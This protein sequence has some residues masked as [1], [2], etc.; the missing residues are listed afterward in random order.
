MNINGLTPNSGSSEK[1]RSSDN[2]AK[3]SSERLSSGTDKSSSA[4][5]VEL[6]PEAKVLK[7]LETQVY[8]MSD[9]DQPK[10]DRIKSAIQNGEYTINYDRLAE[11]MENFET[12]M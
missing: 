1:T 9:V 4:D 10:I 11:A 12:D 8:S 7:D 2:V 3:S 5:T 6:S